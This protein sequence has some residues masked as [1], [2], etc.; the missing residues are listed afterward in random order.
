MNRYSDGDH[1][2]HHF[3]P[4]GEIGATIDALRASLPTFV[5]QL[6]YFGDDEN[7]D[8]RRPDT[9]RPAGEE[10]PATVDLMQRLV[11]TAF[12]SA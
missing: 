2:D 4:L 12:F 6:H 7:P 8:E 9:P 11:R 10:D 3:N 1:E 5:N